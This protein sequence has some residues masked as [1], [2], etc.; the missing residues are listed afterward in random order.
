MTALT[1]ADVEA[2]ALSW[3]SGVGWH[4][5]HGPDIAPDTVGAERANYRQVA[6]DRRLRD[7]L[8]LVNPSLPAA[9]LD[10]AVRKLTQ[11]EGSTPEACNRAFH[12]MLVNGVNVEY[13]S[14]R[15]VHPGRPG[16]SH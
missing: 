2:E 15:R 5:A 6:L 3:L 10:D 1:E 8:A 14:Q 4:V 7:V 13:R 9:A 16:P 12:R 11:P